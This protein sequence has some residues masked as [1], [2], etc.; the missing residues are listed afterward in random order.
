[1][2]LKEFKIGDKVTVS[3]EG[4]WQND[5]FGTICDGPEQVDVREGSEYFYWVEF[6][7][8][9]HDLSD[10]GPYTKAQVLSQYISIRS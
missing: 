6:D 9:E 3:S 4:G 2:R 10:D 5:C 1:M 8:P 7:A